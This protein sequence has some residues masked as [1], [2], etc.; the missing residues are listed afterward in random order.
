MLKV[1]NTLTR[2][3]EVFKP[4]KNN[5]VNL[6]TCGPTVYSNSHLGHAK[7]YI[8]FDIIAKYLRYKGFNLFYLQNI[9]DVDDKIIKRAN[10]GKTDWKTLSRK[11]E[12]SYLED[13]KNLGVDSINKYARATD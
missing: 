9:T 6:F 4:L 8:Q 13:M 5:K 1:Y 7:T 12:Q 2:K 11:Y 3:L 10:E